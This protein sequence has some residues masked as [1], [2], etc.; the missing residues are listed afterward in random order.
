MGLVR[1]FGGPLLPAL[2]AA[3]IFAGC[4]DNGSETAT[5]QGTVAPPE[6]TNTATS[7]G[8]VDHAQAVL[9]GIIER[10]ITDPNYHSSGFRSDSAISKDLIDKIDQLDEEAK[11]SGATGLDFDPFVCTQNVPE[12]VS[13]S[14]GDAATQTRTI[15]GHLSFGTG[16][17]RDVIYDMGREGGGWKLVST[18]C[19][20]E[21]LRG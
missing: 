15:I 20:A 18:S 16:G 1:R 21:A 6:V 12:N 7:G 5:I 9:E 2:T 8:D 13:Y 3:A 4:D 19:V 17:P 14:P 10:D 11:E